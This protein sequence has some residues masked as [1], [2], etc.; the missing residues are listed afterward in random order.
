MIGDSRRLAG[1]VTGELG[2]VTVSLQFQDRTRQMLDHM[3]QILEEG[4]VQ[5]VQTAALPPGP[6]P[7]AAKEAAFEAASRHFTIR[8]EWA[9]GPSRSSLPG[10]KSV[11]LF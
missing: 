4:A 7:V 2:D 5:L 1:V 9:L 11:E 8:E 10:T 3:A 6:V